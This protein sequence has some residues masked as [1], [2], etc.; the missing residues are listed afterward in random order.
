MD[1]LG[2]CNPEEKLILEDQRIKVSDKVEIKA[3]NSENI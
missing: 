2:K 3:K 1:I